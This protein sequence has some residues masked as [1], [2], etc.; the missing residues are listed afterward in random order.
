MGSERNNVNVQSEGAKRYWTEKEW[1]IYGDLPWVIR[2]F[3]DILIR[4][5]RFVRSA[6]ADQIRIVDRRFQFAE[7]KLSE[8]KNQRRKR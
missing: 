6:G 3:V 1:R 4:V 8:A 2:K 5:P 7:R